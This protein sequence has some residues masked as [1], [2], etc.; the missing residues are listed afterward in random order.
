MVTAPWVV[1]DDPAPATVAAVTGTRP[2]DPS[3]LAARVVE[4]KPALP[5][6][7]PATWVGWTAV[8]AS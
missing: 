5:R 4:Y 7:V 1:T 3:S 8:G 6:T 2:V